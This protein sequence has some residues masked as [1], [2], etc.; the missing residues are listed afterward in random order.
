MA[1]VACRAA[2]TPGRWEWLVCFR[3]GRKLARG[4]ATRVVRREPIGADEELKCRDCGT[5]N[6]VGLK[7]PT[8]LH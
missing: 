7:D 2:A 3:C 4:I 1:E 5:L 6:Y 8:A